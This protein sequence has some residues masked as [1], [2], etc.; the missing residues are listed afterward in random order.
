MCLL[1]RDFLAKV[2]KIFLADVARSLEKDLS[3]SL[4]VLH[5]HQWRWEA[6]SKRCRRLDANCCPR[7]LEIA[8]PFEGF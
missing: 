6:Q 1:L 3:E 2:A 5:D 8:E 4:I 7:W